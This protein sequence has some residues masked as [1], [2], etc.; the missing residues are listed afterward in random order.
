MTLSEQRILFSQLISE[1]VLWV[2]SN[3][4]EHALAFDQVK[5]DAAAAS[6]NAQ[7][8]TGIANSLHLSGLAADMLLYVGGT[9]RADTESYRQIGLHWKSMHPLN[10]WG[11]DFTTRPD[12]NHFSSMRG[13]VQ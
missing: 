5:R 1:L 2:S 12:G 9:Y 3:L 10:R 8:G 4:P 11:G 6:A 13:G 7:A